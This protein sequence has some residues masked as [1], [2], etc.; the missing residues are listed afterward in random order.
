MGEI[1]REKFTGATIKTRRVRFFWQGTHEKTPFEQELDVQMKKLDEK[2]RGGL[3]KILFGQPR[4]YDGKWIHD[5]VWGQGQLQ[6]MVGW[7]LQELV[8]KQEGMRGGG[9]PPVR[10]VSGRFI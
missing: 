6:M 2:G 5:E 9:T 3:D 10:L 7:L 8:M 1:V 4:G